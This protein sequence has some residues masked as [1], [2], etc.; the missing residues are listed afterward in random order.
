[1]QKEMKVASV[2]SMNRIRPLVCY[3]I[4]LIAGFVGI[5]D[6]LSAIVPKLNWDILLGA[7]P[8]VAHKI[9]AQT[10][11]VVV[12]FF[13]IMLSYGLMRSKAHAWHLTLVLLLLSGLLHVLRGGS[14]LATVV[15]LGLALVLCCLRNFFLARSDPPSVWR[16]YIALT[17]GLGVVVFYTIGGFI[18]L[19]DDFNPLIDRF[20]IEVFAL[21]IL[22]NAHMVHIA[23]GTPAFLFGH[24]LPVLCISAVLYGMVQLFR[25]VAAVL[26]PDTE[27]RYEVAQLTR[28][29]GKSSISYFAMGLDKSY[30]F[31]ESGKSVISYVL[32]GSTAVV[33]GD[34]IGPDHETA[35]VIEQFMNF[36]HVQSWTAVFWQ[37]RAEIADLYREAGLHLLKIGEDAIINTEKFTLKG[38]AMANVRSSAKRAEKEDVHVV[39]YR[40]RISDFE[41]LAQME[42]ISHDWLVSKGGM[43]MGFSMG[44]FDPQSNPELMY[45]VAVD[46]TNRVHAFVNFVPI[47][48]REGWGLDLMRRAARCAPGTMELLLARSIEYLKSC[49]AQT[50]SLGLAPLGNTNKDDETFLGSSIDFLTHRFGDPEKNRSLFNF[51]KKFHPIWESRYLVYSDAL[52]LPKIGLAL[53]SA[54]QRDASLLSTAR[55]SLASWRRNMRKSSTGKLEALNV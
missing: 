46:K 26:L 13:L 31:S 48:G 2:L 53:Y 44:H 20:G 52:S 19:Y 8:F 37:V 23:R 18:A 40:G 7:W 51:K 27:E 47:Y 41:Q 17:L 39:F 33:A 29:Y 15:A 38:G 1:M 34:P 36:C 55:A 30:F 14:I 49:G 11:T 43:E 32:V 35:A 3:T 28:L 21:R 42:R 45:A 25:P 54:H 22:T 5:A 6:M 9:P 24:A 50:I 10:L 12:G 4:G 16:G